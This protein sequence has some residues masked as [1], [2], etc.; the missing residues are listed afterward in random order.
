MQIVL[1]GTQ[2]STASHSVYNLKHAYLIHDGLRYFF[3]LGTLLKA[4]QHAGKLGYY[5]MPNSKAHDVVKLV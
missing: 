4:P 3:Y 1:V 5:I 2:N